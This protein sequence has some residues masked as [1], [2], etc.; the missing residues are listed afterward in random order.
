[1]PI[2]LFYRYLWP[3]NTL[4]E[5]EPVNKVDPIALQYDK[6]YDI[7]AN[8]LDVY[9]TDEKAIEELLT[10]TVTN[11]D[12]TKVLPALIG[13]FGLRA[14]HYLEKFTNLHHLP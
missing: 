5:G 14:K 3:D 12:S 6:K 13:S 11:S 7:T 10:I 1:M 4:D 2:F 9:N 8:Q